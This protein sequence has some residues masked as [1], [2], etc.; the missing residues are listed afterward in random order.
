MAMLIKGI[1]SKVDKII[2]KGTYKR[3]NS[4]HNQIISDDIVKQVISEPGRFHLIGSWT[5]PWSHRTTIMHKLKGL[6]QHIPLHMTGGNRVEG[7]PA[8]FGKPWLIPGSKKE[9]IHLH[10]LYTTNN[11]SHTG[12]ATVPILWDEKQ[13][14]IISD[15]S[16]K[17][18][19]LFNKININKKNIDF[20]PLKMFDQIN[21]LNDEIYQDLNNGV[22]KAGFAQNQASYD[23]AIKPIFSLLSKLEGI[24]SKQRFLLGE[25]IT[26]SDWRL[27][28]TLVRFDIDYHIH[29]RCT[30]NR[31]VDYPSLWA[32]TRDLYSW[33]GIQDTLDF[34][35]IHL[36]NFK[37]VKIVAIMPD[38]DW[39][40]PHNRDDF[41]MVKAYSND[42]EIIEME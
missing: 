24:L 6:L 36:S 17:I 38:I 29:S 14:C 7:Y 20:V 22:Y 39:H 40:Q 8:N 21:K 31:L 33:N 18:I 12:R 23:L 16:S 10:Q 4:I 9:I 35:A 32:Y 19:R 37:D 2:E 5:C 15:E 41:G 25:T 27:F 3:Q 28:V 1:W 13:Q 11:P 30:Q 42:G 26:E 34:N